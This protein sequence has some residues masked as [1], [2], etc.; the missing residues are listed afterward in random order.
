MSHPTAYPSDPRA[1]TSPR[2][3]PALAVIMLAATGLIA[4]HIV[5]GN[6]PRCCRQS[7]IRHA[8]R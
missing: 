1:T 3:R 7:T 8:S 2:F 4:P 5:Q 6:A